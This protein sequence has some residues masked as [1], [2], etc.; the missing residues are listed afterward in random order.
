MEAE[1]GVLCLGEEIS[2]SDRSEKRGIDG[3]ML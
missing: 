2:A 3:E 1:L